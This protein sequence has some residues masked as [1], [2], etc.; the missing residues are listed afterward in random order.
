MN[1]STI[2]KVE[3]FRH[4]LNQA[5]KGKLRTAGRSLPVRIDGMMESRPSRIVI[6][7]SGLIGI[8]AALLTIALYF[9][10]SSSL[11]SNAEPLANAETSQQ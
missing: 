9:W 10:P 7:L 11:D 4:V 1:S 2:S 5:T 3:F 8:P 6:F